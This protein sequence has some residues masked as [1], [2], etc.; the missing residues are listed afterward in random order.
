[1]RFLFLTQYFHPET[2]ASQVRLASLVRELSRMGHRVE[3]VTA[4]PNYPA[5][6]IFPEF[7]GK[8]YEKA[9]WEG[10]PIHRV[11]LYASMGGGLKR[12]LNY[13][14]FTLTCVWGLLRAKRADCVFVESPPLFLSIPGWIAAR[15]WRAKL[16]FNVADLWPDSVEQLG[17]MRDGALLRFARALEAWSYRRADYVNAVTEKMK[18]ILLEAKR[19]PPAK[20][21][22]LPN[23]VDTNLF[24][25]M[26][27]DDEL[28]RQL[29]LQEKQIFLYAGNH[30]Y[31][32]GLE[33]A[34]HA[35]KILAHRE[36]IHFLF[37][38][39]GSDKP[40]L[41]ELARVLG[42]QNVTF[43]NPVPVNALP[44][45]MSIADFGLVTLRKCSLSEGARPAK[46]FVMLASGKPIV[47]SASGE[48]TQIVGESG[49]GIVV[50]PGD[51]E[52]IA[53]AVLTLLDNPS[54]AQAMGARGRNYVERRFRWDDLIRNWLAQM[55]NGGA[56]SSIF[57]AQRA[58]EVKRREPISGVD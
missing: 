21:L 24:R 33:H 58:G 16:I 38:G 28:A 54:M 39:D 19:V 35:A 32:A 15:A 23:G 26:P 31:I 9:V 25:P 51:P 37:V 57:D 52:E 50:P 43:L 22:F 55:E 34:L 5:G 3:V 48:G 17:I 30:G 29:G 49:A 46:T 8:F 14:S 10:V 20:V 45:Y 40:R 2:G 44:R 1:M 7:R 6:A 42:L 11:W 12:L 41:V 47:M 4:F 18:A 56:S 13:L 36:E 27:R 53:S